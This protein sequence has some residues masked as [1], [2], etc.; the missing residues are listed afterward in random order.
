MKRKMAHR[1]AIFVV[2]AI[3][4]ISTAR[5]ETPYSIVNHWSIG[6]TGGWDYLAVDP[7][8]HHLYITH[9]SRLEVID[10]ASGKPITAITG[11]KG[12]HGVAFDDAGK[13]G[14]ASDGGANAVVVF[15]R[16]SY[17][18]LASI[19]TGTNPDGIAFEP[20]THT[21]WAFNGRSKNATVID[22]AK[23]TVVA[24]IPLPGKPEFPAV[25]GSG[26]VFVNI[27]DKNEIMRLDAATLKATATWP[28]D[29]CDSPSGLA[30]DLPG[31]RLFSV[32]DGKK[33][34]VTDS[35]TGKKLA[36]PDIGDGPD[37]A[38]YDPAHKLAFSSN[39]SGTLSIIDAANA[40]YPS[41]QTIPTARGA[42][43]MTYD[44]GT[45]RAYIVT[46]EFGP[47]PAPTA[48]NPHPWPSVLPGTFRVIVVGRK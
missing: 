26:T 45:D 27:E 35:K 37:A 1:F 24:T 47:P 43:T 23:R 41:V 22:A 10:T 30:I 7:A 11:F 33:M 2:A 5:S 15:D 38:A 48:Q 8:T 21:V 34:I 12:L 3:A 46:A 20:R 6:G 29:G 18:K 40:S 4:V 28:L 32:C 25:D 39:G 13:L 16:T 19:P 42:R 14:Y 36:L 31:H 44:P 9:G 17:A